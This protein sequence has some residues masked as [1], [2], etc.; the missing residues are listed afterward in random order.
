MSSGDR[1]TAATILC[2]G[3]S[4]TWGWTPP[5]EDRLPRAERWPG[6]LQDELGLSFHVIEEGLN[7]RTTV[8]DVPDQD[9]R[10][11]LD[12][13]PMLLETHAPLDV[14]LIALGINDI[15]V[16][17]V[18][19]RWSAK[20]IQRL[21]EVVQESEAGSSGDPPRCVVLAPPPVGRLREDWQADAPDANEV[22]RAL[23][24]EYVAV[25]EP[26][27]VPVLDLG[28]VCMPPDPDGLHLDAEGHHAVGSLVAGFLR[29]AT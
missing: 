13:L 5:S 27:G 19:A 15:F 10:R 11:G 4:N 17:G 12:H 6:V 23:F 3:D 22:S 7:G 18:T 1:A 24:P 21:V 26:F 2:F 9:D 28:T 25:C 20:G 29:T 8:F 16:P 14:V